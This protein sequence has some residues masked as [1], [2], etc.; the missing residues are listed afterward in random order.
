MIINSNHQPTA[1][2]PTFLPPAPFYCDL[3]R[4]W[5]TDLTPSQPHNFGGALLAVNTFILETLKECLH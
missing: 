1:I 4:L 3:R 2:M 5:D